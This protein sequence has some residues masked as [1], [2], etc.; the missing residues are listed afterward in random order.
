MGSSGDIKELRLLQLNSTKY[1]LKTAN[2]TRGVDDFTVTCGIASRTMV[3]LTKN[4]KASC[5]G[6][7]PFFLYFF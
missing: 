5:V 6:S 7:S 1:L 3:Q 4:S 2:A